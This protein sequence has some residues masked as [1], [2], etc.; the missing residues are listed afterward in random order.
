MQGTSRENSKTGDSVTPHLCYRSLPT[1]D[2]ALSAKHTN[3]D[4]CRGIIC[5]LLGLIWCNDRLLMILTSSCYFGLM[6]RL[7]VLFRH[8]RFAV[9]LQQIFY[10]FC[11]ELCVCYC[12]P[13][14][15]LHNCS[16][17]ITNAS[18]YFRA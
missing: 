4:G 17:G 5:A 3:R 18:N 2:G 16:A 10:F 15:T 8:L 7:L 13:R 9:S 14:T 11:T 1:R 12:K 6:L